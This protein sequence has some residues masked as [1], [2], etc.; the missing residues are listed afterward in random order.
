MEKEK[1]KLINFIRE[2]ISYIDKN[3]DNFPKKD[4]E[5]K[6]RIRNTSYDLLEIAYIANTSM[7]V[8]YKI[9]LIEKIIAKV[10]IIDFLLNMCYDKQII[11]SKRYFKFGEKL[12]DIIKYANGW[13][14]ALES[15]NSKTKK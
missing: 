10:K 4:I 2:L 3:L 13:K 6:N 11:N 12:D 8:E 5:L 9:E 1:F 15:N 14:K 7:N